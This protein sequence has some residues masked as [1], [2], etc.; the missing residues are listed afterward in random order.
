MCCRWAGPA[1]G[2][3]VMEAFLVMLIP[4][5][6]TVFVFIKFRVLP[7]DRTVPLYWLPELDTATILTLNT[8]CLLSTRPRYMSAGAV[9]HMVCFVWR[10][11]GAGMLISSAAVL[12]LAA[13]LVSLSV[14]GGCAK[15]QRQSAVRG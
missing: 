15:E 9:T 1:G 6:G 2:S 8:S 5:S 13:F 11:A 3:A 10:G 4:G 14:V 12:G 7:V